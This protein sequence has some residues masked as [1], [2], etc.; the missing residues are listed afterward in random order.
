VNN[1]IIIL[2]IIENNI[3]IHLAVF[4]LGISGFMV[5]KHIYQ[6]KK[7]G[8]VLVCP[9]RFDCNT[10]VNSDYS[11]FFGIPVEILGMIYYCLISLAHTPFIFYANLSLS[12]LTNISITLST[13]AFIFSAYLIYLQF[14]VIK[15]G[16]SWCFV[17]ATNSTL[18]FIFSL[19][20]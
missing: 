2:M 19:L 14:F 16:C 9:I 1:D 7:T 3:L 20:V 17:S 18:I 12:L 5:S 10:V 6:H 11:R 13:L 8:Q 4:I 15:K